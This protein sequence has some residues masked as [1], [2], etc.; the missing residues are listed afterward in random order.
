[1]GYGKILV[2][3]DCFELVKE[4]LQQAI[5]LGQKEFFQLMVFYCILVDSQDLSIYFS[6]YGEVVIGFFQIIKEY[7]EE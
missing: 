1:M 2:V 6:F 3:L 4:V 7:L 5:V